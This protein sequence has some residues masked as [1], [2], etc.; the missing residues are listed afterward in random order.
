MPC[1]RAQLRAARAGFARATNLGLPTLDQSNIRGRSG[2]GT[3]TGTG[4]GESAVDKH[5]GIRHSPRPLGRTTGRAFL[6]VVPDGFFDEA[7]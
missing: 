4:T 2:T 1:L 6:K 3:G 5:W 7:D